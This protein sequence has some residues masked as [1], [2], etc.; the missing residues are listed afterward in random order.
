MEQKGLPVDQILRECVASG[1]QHIIDIGISS[2]DL[3]ARRERFGACPIVRF[4]AG[5]HPMNATSWDDSAS[6]MA[7]SNAT[8]S[9]ATPSGVVD[10]VAIGETGLDWYRG[11]ETADAQVCAFEAQLHLACRLGLPVVIHNRDATSDVYHTLRKITPPAGGVMHCYSASAEWVA[12]FVDLGFWISFAGNITYKSATGL[13]DAA[14][15]VPAD[16]ILSE[17]D[18]PF[19]SPIPARGKPNHPGYI[20][21]TI[22]LLAEIRDTP[23]EALTET[24]ATNTRAVFRL[25][26]T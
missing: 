3:P 20:A 4:T 18:A 22:R 12:R 21:H 16:R 23:V 14:R 5:V 2:D 7:L 19:L 9:S 6:I 8:S 25:G 24:I 11:R 10:A 1:L 17:T 13:R 15:I 26:T